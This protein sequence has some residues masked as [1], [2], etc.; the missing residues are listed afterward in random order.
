MKLIMAGLDFT[1]AAMET[2]EAFSLSGP[3]VIETLRTIAKSGVSGCAI[4]STCN[5]T[6]LYLSADGDAAPDGVALL[7][8]ALGV[9]A[10]PARDGFAVRSG[11]DAL[12][13]LMRVAGGMRSS[14]LGDD[15][16]I[17]QVRAAMDAARE[18]ETSDALLEAVFRAA[19]TAGKKIKCRVSFAREGG[20]VAAEAVRLIAAKLGQ[21][22]GRR[23][24]VVGNGVI[25]RLTATALF[26]RGCEVTVTVRQFRHGR[27]LVPDGCEGVAYGE[28]Y[29][30]MASCDILVSATASP[31][32]TVTAAEA[33]LLPSLPRVMA[34][35]AIPRDIEPA[36]GKLP[37]VTL[38]NVDDLR[39]PG[40]SEHAAQ[41]DLA[42]DIIATE[43][44]RFEAW[45]HNRR[46]RTGAVNGAPADFPVFINM[47]GATA[48][49]VG[50]GKVAARRAD[51]LLGFGARVRMVAPALAEGAQRLREREG[52]EWIRDSYRA[53]H[54]DGVTL[55]VAATDDREV[56]RRVGLDAR[57]RGIL[58][59]VADRREECSFY[60]PAII[61]TNVLT[62]GLV[63]NNGDH[64]LVK[65][66]AATLRRD[67]IAFESG[68]Q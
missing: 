26:E 15:Q 67:L 50:G 55:V 31:H 24:L 7:C 37:G 36:V 41:F 61:K 10:A 32:H 12:E 27:A 8:D 25:G 56:N 38:W 5:R 46:H 66:A 9:D 35:L 60:F 19:V 65:R 57:E 22:D 40:D 4:V 29:A 63:S 16:I 11:R 23:A 54:M 20:S 53:D 48:L 18:A 42:N 59:S 44:D 2:R 52:V 64:A 45:R 34:D 3:R 39:R 68:E 49:L 21:L 14:V 17:T 51:I 1:T 43:A 13:H 58:V 47:H 6:E 28:R 62:A 33:S 30:A